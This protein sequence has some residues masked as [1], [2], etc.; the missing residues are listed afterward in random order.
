M[1]WLTGNKGMLG[2]DVEQKLSA[3][4]KSFIVS[5]REV[6]ITDISCIE[7][8][9]SKKNCTS[10]HYIIN[11][12]AYTAVDKAES[13][14][15]NAF[16]LNSIGPGNL[17]KVAKKTGAALIH[18]STDYVFDGTK[19]DSYNE[20]DP[21]NP[22]SV[23]GKSKLEGEKN[24]QN[25][26]EHYF[27]LRTA[28]LYG[29]NGKNFIKTMIALFEKRDELSI[30]ADQKGNPSYT[31]DLAD[32]IMVIINR[33]SNK[34]GI[35][36]VTNAGETTWFNL[37]KE[38]LKYCKEKAKITKDVRLLPITTKEY[39]TPATRPANSCLNKAKL[40]DQLGIEMRL[41]TTALYDFLEQE[42]W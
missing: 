20:D 16:S 38:I 18:I 9:L 17:A 34:Y 14:P 41:W 33:H 4:E 32:V 23:Y 40:K 10:L 5:D 6:D 36:H 2:S 11:C 26:I 13:E 1:I 35:Y 27:I 22:L 37:A 8:F 29:K 7:S 39:P 42:N 24:I 19:A 28:W 25:E 15:E 21:T 30:V 3:R 12:A 31:K